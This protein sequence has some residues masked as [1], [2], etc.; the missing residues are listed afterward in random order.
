MC[1]PMN[2]AS[3]CRLLLAKIGVRLIELLSRKLYKLGI[4]QTDPNI[5]L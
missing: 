4:A 5:S 3:V 1:K 2:Y